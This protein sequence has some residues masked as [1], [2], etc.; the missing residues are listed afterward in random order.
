MYCAWPRIFTC[1]QVTKFH[2]HGTLPCMPSVSGS[3]ECELL[4]I[5]YCVGVMVHCV[6]K[7]QVMCWFSRA[8]SRGVEK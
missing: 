2:R 1:S 3:Y 7:G 6:V 5:V 8:Q 4:S